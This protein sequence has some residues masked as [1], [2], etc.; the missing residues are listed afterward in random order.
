MSPTKSS[1]RTVCDRYELQEVLG[2][3]G[4]GTVW[5]ARD[6][7][8]KRTVA[9][10]EVR[11]PEE[12]DA[13]D[14]SA[15][16]ARALRE[17]RAAAKLS[18]PTVVTM[19]D[20]QEDDGRIYLVMELIDG[21]SLA[22]VIAQ[23]GPLDPE[24]AARMGLDVLTALE[25]AHGAGVVHRDVKPGN[26]ML[27]EGDSAKLADFGIAS[28][29]DDPKITKTGLILGSPSYMAPEQVKGQGA[30]PA[31]DLWALGATLFYAVEGRPPFE[32]GQ[33]IP[34]LASVVDD[35]PPPM[36]RAGRL[37]PIIRD[38]LN[39]DPQARPTPAE[40]CGSD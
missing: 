28:L 30:G 29:K 24:R 17:A 14:R 10:K 20:V 40:S 31:T 39:K 1:Q 13:E 12:V 35:E 38:M 33:A 3:G 18:Q 22:D 27:G 15:L 9:V 36:T 21:P 6:L 11:L 26:I 16:E 4:M 25:A 7:R 23:E 19:F 32:K 8:L 5:R 2:R 37:E 34:T